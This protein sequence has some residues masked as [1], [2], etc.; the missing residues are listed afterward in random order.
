MSLSAALAI[1]NSGLAN[2]NVQFGVVSQNV[3]NASTS[4]Y[5]QEVAT[6]TAL[7]AQ[8]DPLGVRS[9]VVTR[10]IDASTQASLTSQNAVVTALQTRQSALQGIDDV[11]GTVAAAKISP[12]SLV[13]WKM[14]SP[15]YKMIPRARRSSKRSSALHRP[16]VPKSTNY[17]VQSEPRG[18]THRM[19]WF[20][21]LPR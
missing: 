2:I 17:P 21:R 6:Q 11:Q 9:G 15:H 1:A 3:A 19:S 4:G 10:E 16:S 13:P 8:G 18:R 20:L 5:A 14:P 12:V 7:T